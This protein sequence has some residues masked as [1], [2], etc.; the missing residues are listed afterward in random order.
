M[1]IIADMHNHTIASTHAYSTVAELMAMGAERGLL[2]VAITDHAPTI[3]DAPHEWHFSGLRRLPKAVHGVRLLSGAEINVSDEKGTLDL[4][5]NL[6]KTMNFVIASMHTQC[7]QPT[8]KSSH[9]EAWLSM[10]NNPLV[11]CFGHAGQ[12]QYVFDIDVVVKECAK[13]GTIFE[14][15]NQ[16]FVIRKE[17]ASNCEK[18]AL[19][20][21]REGVSI[22]VNSDSHSAW[23]IG[24]FDY[25]LEMLGR[26]GFPEELVINS[27]KE[28]LGDYF[29]KR[30]KLDI[31]NV[32]GM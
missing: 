22:A 2:A 28:R 10:A 15:N 26:I 1:T 6:V 20:C 27:S 12:P 32:G 23:D 4:P 29:M 5:D 14:I 18:I 24:R 31:W 30:K 9:T 11:D 7:F 25:A 3:P 16:S 13:T 21:M 17:S 19:A 8:T